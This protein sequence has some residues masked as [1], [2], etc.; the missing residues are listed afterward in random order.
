LRLFYHKFNSDP[1]IPGWAY[2]AIFT[3]LQLKAFLGSSAVGDGNGIS[4]KESIGT[5]VN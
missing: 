3:F 5:C 1:K 2:V 4:V